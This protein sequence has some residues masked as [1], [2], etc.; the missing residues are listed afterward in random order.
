MGGSSAWPPTAAAP[1]ATALHQPPAQ[2]DSAMTDAQWW[3]ANAEL[4]ARVFDPER[5]P[6][7]ARV[8][9][10][11]GAAHG[12]AYDPDHAYAFGLARV[13][14]GLEALIRER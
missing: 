1:T 10:A 9:A 6:V 8:C 2:Q 3:Q 5:H 4:P 7:A 11:A 12:G 14:D 13:L